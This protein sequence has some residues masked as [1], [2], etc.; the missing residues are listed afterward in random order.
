MDRNQKEATDFIK[1]AEN[2]FKGSLFGNLFGNKEDRGDKAIESYTQAANLFKLSKMFTEA[3]SCYERIADIQSQIG[4]SSAGAYEE[5]AHV[6]SFSD[7]QSKLI[8]AN[9]IRNPRRN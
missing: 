7:P 3:G 9:S 4:I 5:A 6:Y 2:D 1:K 8:C